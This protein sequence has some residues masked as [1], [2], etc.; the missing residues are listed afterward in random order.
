MVD[1]RYAIIVAGGSGVR[2]NVRT[3][4]QFLL[5]NGLPILMHTI[6][7]FQSI[8]PLPEIVLVLPDNQFETWEKLC[9]EYTFNVHYK[10]VAGGETRF[11]SVKNGLNAI[12]GDGLV[13]IHDGVRPLVSMAIIENCFNV[14]KQKGNAVPAIQPHESV[15][16][17]SPESSTAENRENI[18]L[19]QT[20]QV[21]R[22]NTIKTS[23]QTN[24]SI[25]F[26]DDASVAE[27]SGEKIH[28]VQGDRENIKIT[29]QLDLITAEELIRKGATK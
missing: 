7:L 6:N 16:V 21:F 1:K 25:S 5:L 26:T 15:R 17:G 10:L 24:F 29:T 22:V 13:A 4:K 11:H 19:I 2:M 3:P 14:A 12:D 23:Y 20:P 9:H 8:N 18:W 28:L 27:A